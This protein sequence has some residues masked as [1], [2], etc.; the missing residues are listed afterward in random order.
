MTQFAYTLSGW[1]A[2][3]KYSLEN[4]CNCNTL[5]DMYY[6]ITWVKQWRYLTHQIATNWHWQ[7][8]NDYTWSFHLLFNA[9]L[10]DLHHI[11]NEG[12]N[13]VLGHQSDNP[14]LKER[15]GILMNKPLWFFP[16][17]RKLISLIENRISNLSHIMKIKKLCPQPI[18]YD[19]L[20]D[21]IQPTIMVWYFFN[22]IFRWNCCISRPQIQLH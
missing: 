1:T 13:F 19:H 17:C 3:R 7:V 6:H 16:L 2:G 20:I 22:H 12:N 18:C 5:N 15:I 9:K 11:I 21:S 10:L 4:T 8:G 14:L